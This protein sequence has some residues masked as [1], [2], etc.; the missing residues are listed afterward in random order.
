M[1][2][3][4]SSSFGADAGQNTDPDN[5]E[6]SSESDPKQRSKNSSSASDE[7]RG[8][9]SEI[10]H[11]DVEDWIAKQEEKERAYGYYHLCVRA[12][13]RLT[14]TEHYLQ[15]R[16]EIAHPETDDLSSVATTTGVTMGSPNPADALDQI[17]AWKIGL[18]ANPLHPR[19]RDVP[20]ERLRVFIPE[21]AI[22]GLR[23]GGENADTV[24]SRLN[25]MDEH[26]PEK[27]YIETVAEYQ[28][29]RD[30]TAPVSGSKVKRVRDIE[31]T[32]RAQLGFDKRL[33]HTVPEPVPKYDGRSLTDL[34]SELTVA[35]EDLE[36]TEQR[37]SVLRDE[38]KQR[39][40]EW[41]E[42][43]RAELFPDRD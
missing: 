15:A 41:K 6:Q 27:E 2:S 12:E 24:M 20:A 23:D 26:E 22:E 31:Q 11:P 17:I 35:R 14:G 7:G 8:Q 25:G 18:M 1:Q 40:V 38:V 42:D 28:E 32:L 21:V 13:S 5:N 3:D 34:E 37:K 9:V 36:E 16:G 43:K 33:G 30:A 19:T 10:H 29:A 4:L 39:R